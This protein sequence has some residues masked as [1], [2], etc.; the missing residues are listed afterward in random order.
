MVSS[1]VDNTQPCQVKKPSADVDFIWEKVP[2]VPETWSSVEAVNIVGSQT[3]ELLKRKKKAGDCQCEGK[4]DITATGE[5]KRDQR[6]SL[7]S[8]TC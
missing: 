1:D 8:S 7:K 2:F 5:E 6:R 3:V 4:K